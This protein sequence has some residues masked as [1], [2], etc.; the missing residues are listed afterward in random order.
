MASKLLKEYLACKE[1]GFNAGTNALH[2]KCHSP[3]YHT[4]IADGTLI[5]STREN[6]EY[7]LACL[8]S[9]EPALLERAMRTVTAVLDMQDRDPLSKSYGIWPWFMEEPIEKMS[10]PD[11]NWADFIGA[12]IIVMLSRHAGRLPESFRKRLEEALGHAARS[13]FRRNVDPGYTN[14]AIMGGC[15]VSAAGEL[16]AEPWLLDYGRRRLKAVVELAKFHGAFN[17]FN[18]PTYTIVAI[19]ECERLLAVVKDQEARQRAVELLEIAWGTVSEHFHAPSSQWCGPHARA[20][21]DRLTARTAAWIAER[22]GAK[23]EA[24]PSMRTEGIDRID[25]IPAVPC[26]AKFK[27]RFTDA[28]AD[29]T[30]RSRFFRKEPE[31]ASSWACSWM[32]AEA[33]L[34]SMNA[35]SFWNQSRPLIGYWASKEDPAAVFRLKALK[36]GRDFCAGRTRIAQEGP[37]ALAVCDFA[38]GTGDFHP[39][40][41][42][43]SDGIFPCSDLRFRFELDANG[44]SVEELEGKSWKL[45]AGGRCALI[46]AGPSSFDGKE[47]E[48]KAGAEGSKVFLDAVCPAPQGGS[49]RIED[50][51]KTLIVAGVSLM[52]ADAKAQSGQVESSG[53]AASW[54]PRKGVSLRTPLP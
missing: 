38:T 18:S 21:S 11:W 53:G 48:W 47:L 44:A 43:T 12:A 23:I 6:M 28:P 22:T 45:S 39:T 32:D 15:V 40:L 46:K 31:S 41:D 25:P 54:T 3:G 17:E 20:Y 35:G 13:I 34:G 7:A 9:R 16:L 5:R 49:L 1:S 19:E 52:R 50:L 24:H 4:R 14:I 26:P 10:P 51:G 8:D 36:D 29:A 37:D 2:A 30:I 27:P 33:C 42:R